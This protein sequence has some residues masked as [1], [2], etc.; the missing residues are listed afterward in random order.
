M[1]DKVHSGQTQFPSKHLIKNE[2]ITHNIITI[3]YNKKVISKLTSL[4]ALR[5]KKFL[6]KIIL[7]KKITLL[8]P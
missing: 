5:T 2:N 1:Q 3:N 6:I 7:I 4:S 8:I